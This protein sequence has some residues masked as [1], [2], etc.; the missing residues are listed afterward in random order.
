LTSQLTPLLMS[1]ALLAGCATPP[2]PSLY[3]GTVSGRMSLQVAASPRA[4][5]SHFTGGFE[6]QGDARTGRFDLLSP[7]GTLVARATWQPDQ[8]VLEADGRTIRFSSLEE[9]ARRTLGEAVP[10]E[11]LADWLRGR[12]WPGAPHLPR[13]GF[14]EQGGWQID[15]RRF[16]E[17]FISARR[18][19]PAPEVN[20]R[21]RLEGSR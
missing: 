7:V 6:L 8:V 14:F 11:A 19:T 9:L 20:L 3:E 13:E 4:M 18:L 5:A 15:T 1:A 21:A 17:G 2:P 16:A 10:L 12:P